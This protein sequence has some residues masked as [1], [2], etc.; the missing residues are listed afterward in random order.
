MKRLGESARPAYFVAGIEQLS[1]NITPMRLASEYSVQ[2]LTVPSTE[3]VVDETVDSG[4]K[5]DQQIVDVRKHEE[6]LIV[7]VG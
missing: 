4:V 2:L 3:S 7:D 5:L 6:K 1:G